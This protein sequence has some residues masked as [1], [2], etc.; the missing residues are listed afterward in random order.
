M[1]R[2]IK[3][4]NFPVLNGKQ[5]ATL[6]HA[7]VNIEDMGERTI[8]TQVKIDGDIVPDFS[9]DWEIEFKG[10]KYIMPLRVP[11]GS[12][13]NDSLSASVDLTFQYWPVYQLKRWP[14]VTI[15]PIGAGTYLAD[16][17]VA[18]V[19]LNLHDFCDLFGQVL[20]Y[21]YSGAI[22]IDLNP[23][24]EYSA[25]P[26]AVEI[27]HSYIWDVL[28]KLY[29]LF[30][31]RWEI[32]A[33]PD[34]SNT[35][36]GGERY[37]IKVG[38]PTTEV[39]HIFEYGFEGGLLKVER[40]VQSADIRNLIKGRG[41]DKNLPFRYFKDT[42][43]NNP[44][45]Q[46]DPDWVV[47][48]SNIYFTNLRGATFRS[49]VQGWKAA[50]IADTDKDGK[51]L[52]RGYVPVGEENA[53]SPWAYRKGYTDT[54]F[55]P[56]EFV[57]D[58]ITVTP[59]DGDHTVSILPDYAPYVKKGSSIDRYGPLSGTLDNNDDIHPTLQGTGL[60]IAVDV[61]QIESDDVAASTESDAV[62][63][64]FADADKPKATVTLKGNARKD[65]E[66]K[67]GRFTVEAGR[68][69]NLDEGP[70]SFAVAKYGGKSILAMLTHGKLSLSASA[71]SVEVGDYIVDVEGATLAVVDTLTG[72]ERSA[73]GIPAGEYYFVLRMSLHNTSAD[74]INVTIACDSPR[75]TS[76]TLDDNTWKNTFD[77]W[78]K[79]VWGSER[80]DGESDAEYAER[81][82]RPVL[83][84][85]EGNS[86]KVL[87]TTGNLV[88]DDYEFTIVDYPVP[89][90]SRVWDATDDKGLV[91]ATHRSHWRVKLAK[92]DAEREAT[93]LYVPSTQKQGKAGDRFV[94]IGTEMLH[95]PYVVDAERRLDD[96][97]KDQ[98]GEKKDIK[99]TFVVETDRV[100]LNGEGRADALIN[101][102]RAG[103]T[104]R[105][106]DK[107]FVQP[108]GN[109]AYETLYL[110]SIKYTYREP[111][112]D[113]AALNPDVEI[114]LGNE[115]ATSASTVSTMQSD[116]TALQRQVGSISNI[117]QIVRAVGDRL[118]LRKD[119]IADRSLSPTQFFS[120]LTGGDFRSGLIGGSG[121]GF[122]KD[123]NGDW[124][125]EA[126]RVSVRKDMTVNTLVINQ[127]EGKGGIEIDTAA[128][129]EGVSRVD[130]VEDGYI[131]YFDQKN[132][133]V[134]NLFHVGDVA[135]SSQWTPDNQELKTY[136]R[137]VTE[138]GANYIKLT[139]ALD[140]EHRPADWPD[141][142]AN[143]VG[144]PMPG[145]NI[146]HYGSYTDKTRQYIKVRDVV[147]GGYERYLEDLNS[148]YVDGVEY[149][150]IG[151]QA[152]QTR[153]FV[154]NYDNVPYSGENDGSWIEY[155]NRKF[156]LNNVTLSSTTK[157][158]NE[159]ID[160]Y[161]GRVSPVK[162]EDLAAYDYLKKAL[163]DGATQVL[164]GLLLSSLVRLGEWDKNNPDNPSLSRVWS[165]INGIYTNGQDIAAWYGGDMLDRFVYDTAT[166]RYVPK[167][168]VSDADGYAA[169]AFRM[170]GSAYLAKGNLIIQPDGFTQ[171]GKG[172]SAVTISP[173]GY[174]M[175]GNGISINIGEGAQGLAD[176]LSSLLAAVNG[177][178]NVLY[179]VDAEGKRLNWGAQT[180]NIRAIKS[181]KGFYSDEF[182]SA[183][184]LASGQ[185]SN[186][187]LKVGGAVLSWD[188][189]EGVLKVNGKTIQTAE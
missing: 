57:A 50:H 29:E 82:W 30:A 75:L 187:T 148:A 3:E 128:F 105:L 127:A 69:A 117:E 35:V 56:V 83:G 41:G 149:F 103:N 19:R 125:L 93:G 12:K 108:V 79:N 110:Q 61:E 48:L 170:D 115:Y 60:D 13:G 143:G 118:Y 74:K 164:G 107:R 126:D 180:N 165:G 64:D 124:V 166:H 26:V 11:Q 32:M 78:I 27:N 140:K 152:G 188:E 90:N 49:Y 183:L 98:L 71:F 151:K 131:C 141:D 80:H 72:E 154:G 91:I 43:P 150:F 24:W 134:A 161:I 66:L 21:Y 65:V 51:L 147:G 15:Q 121:W 169:S 129:I 52:Y 25:D 73:S 175:L 138:V 63:S 81:V 122:Y 58:E 116:I 31:V 68:T 59:A 44:D 22:T 130:E 178:S 16:E 174:V 28:T 9:R 45:F 162:K 119:G 86:A 137:R 99:P 18:S 109:R 100:R 10:E 70:K 163:V 2:D 136:R 177:I 1:I 145:D 4:L 168:G 62:V 189:A 144:V 158:G 14:F 181:V 54:K 92:S 7:E 114:V 142:G 155:A 104:I 133:S 95:K 84:D 159:R 85:R 17:E 139:K 160:E 87:F 38:Y 112:S 146:I 6:T 5:Y 106:A 20:D 182:V 94:F 55:R 34:N 111:S 97:K 96:W 23:A 157:I 179:P 176:T 123:A 185:N 67:S 173:D 42:D 39:S 47:E 8:T 172:D 40:Q 156:T 101:Q 89:D 120:L 186:N 132:G 113:D 171:W 102:L 88:H 135:F 153:W 184:G 76:A 53:Y 37:V 46:A 33:A 167:R 36:A 77:I